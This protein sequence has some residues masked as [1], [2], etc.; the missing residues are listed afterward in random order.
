MLLCVFIHR[1]AMRTLDVL[2]QIAPPMTAHQALQSSIVRNRLGAGW[3]TSEDGLA[4]GCV[5]FGAGRTPGAMNP[6]LAPPES[7][8]CCRTSQQVANRSVAKVCGVLE[9]LSKV[10][11]A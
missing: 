10:A 9:Q 6:V 2:T 4:M 11:I 3:N 1:L 7:G 8:L 5:G